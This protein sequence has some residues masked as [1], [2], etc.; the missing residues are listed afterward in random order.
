[1]RPDWANIAHWAT[2]FFGQF[3]ENYR[4]S[5]SVLVRFFPH[6]NFYIDFDKKVLGYSLGDFFTSS[7]CHPEIGREPRKMK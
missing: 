1:V 2:A 6:K 5:P 7:S 3:Y 4:K